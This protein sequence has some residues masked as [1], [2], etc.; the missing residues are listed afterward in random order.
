MGS[1]APVADSVL[2][3][4]SPTF[5]PGRLELALEPIRYI[6]GLPLER[7]QVLDRTGEQDVWEQ[8]LPAQPFL[9]VPKAG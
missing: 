2:D 5:P 3:P 4:T 7:I 8:R 6:G 9:V 1:P